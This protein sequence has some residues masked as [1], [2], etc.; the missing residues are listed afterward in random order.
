MNLTQPAKGNIVMQ[1]YRRLYCHLA[2]YAKEPNMLDKP[3]IVIQ[4]STSL[5][6]RMA[7]A[8]NRTM[9]AEMDDPR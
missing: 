9:W 5:D 8:P 3:F 2:I 6:A 4:V 1:S 7:L